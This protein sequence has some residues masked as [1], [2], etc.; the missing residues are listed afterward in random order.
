MRRL[1]V[2]FIFLFF[3]GYINAQ[4]IENPVFD[5]SDVPEFHIDKIRIAEDTT[6]VY[7][8]YS[9]KAGSWA[10]ISKETYLEDAQTGK[11][12]TILTSN[13]F[14]YRPQIRTFSNTGKYKVELTFPI[15][16][17]NATLLNLIESPDGK[18]FNIYGINLGESN[19]SL[20]NNYSIEQAI[21][22]TSK[23][24]FYH[25]A[26]N[27]IKAIEYEEKAMNIKKAILGKSNDLYEY[28][29]SMLGQYHSA[30]GDS[31]KAEKYLTEDLNLRKAVYGS[32]H[33]MYV[34]ALVSLANCYIK[35]NKITEA[36]KLYEEA[37]ECQKNNKERSREDYAS[38]LAMLADAYFIIGDYPKA[39]KYAEEAVSLF[40]KDS[41]INNEWYF[42]SLLRLAHYKLYLDPEEFKESYEIVSDVIDAII[43]YYGKNN[44]M[45]IAAIHLLSTIC[46][47]MSWLPKSADDTEYHPDQ[48]TQNYEMALSYAQEELEITERLY[49]EKSLQYG[50]ALYGVSDLYS[51]MGSNSKAIEFML[52]SLNLLE[53]KIPIDRYA[54]MLKYLADEYAMIN[55]Y[56]NALKFSEKAI[57][58]LRNYISKTFDSMPEGQKDSYWHKYHFALDSGY[59]TYVYKS[60]NGKALSD[61]YDNLLFFKGITLKETNNTIRWQDVQYTLS[62]KD[63]AI[64]FVTSIEQ[65]S[66][67]VYYA[68]MITK[69]S[70][71]PMMIKLFDILQFGDII[72]LSNSDSIFAMKKKLGNMIWHPMEKELGNVENIFFS[73][74]E[75]IHSI[76]IEYLPIDE[77]ESYSDKYNIYRLS[78]T[79]K[80]LN[81]RPRPHYKKAALFGGLDY[82]PNHT[83]EKVN[84]NIPVRSG[85]DFLWNTEEEVSSISN[86][87]TE[88]GVNTQI[89]K[90]S[91]G[92]EEDVTKLTKDS[93][94]VLH[95]ST[96]GM[97]I[98]QDDIYQNKTNNNLAFLQSRSEDYVYAEDAL[99]WSFL[100]LSGAN[101]FPSR[102]I[103]TSEQNDGILT[104]KEISNLK[105]KDLDL[106]VLSACETAKGHVG[107][108]DSLWGLQYGFKKAG[109]NTIL[110]SL[111]KVDDEATRVLMVEFY[112]NL[113]SGKSKHQSLKDAQQY[114]REYENGKYDDPKY[115]A[116][117]IMLDGLN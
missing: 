103:I 114:L 87:L 58:I 65:D 92:T 19:D 111:G 97:S 23:A 46:R 13:G 76:A 67:S 42:D 32:C 31:R 104:A 71:T 93:L 20:Y 7:C 81:Q 56:E 69:D 89:Y 29:I 61:L 116:S 39:T 64:E 95:M 26:N 79:K 55:D 106:V 84:N 12:Y 108:D 73:P 101:L 6:Y 77:N 105:F 18:G 102:V 88:K 51:L 43:Q 45:Y 35:Q 63:V 48:I 38:T 85:F 74:S 109:A 113:M 70:N 11:K 9:A 15:I 91:E 86:I 25:S 2:V 27:Y 117:F 37:R 44:D 112:R 100:A 21:A 98:K 30:I 80:L 107:I 16:H 8:S 49:G 50:N 10:S 14:P 54:I 22:L 68:L 33:D 78:S 3:I 99:S 75:I 83:D 57:D 28:S 82:S 52:K 60:K 59:P 17:K 94:D 34:L 47:M 115:W 24:D 62:D 110:T 5:R 96:H 36:I 66:L 4:V 53:D 40:K 1:F 90:G 41:V 72:S